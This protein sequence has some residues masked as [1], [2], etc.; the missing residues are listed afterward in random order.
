MG[1]AT[2]TQLATGESV[3]GAVT[4]RTVLGVT[5]ATVVLAVACLMQWVAPGGAVVGIPVATLLGGG[6]AVAGCGIAVL[7][8]GSRLEYIET[9]PSRATSLAAGCVVGMLWAVSGGVAT[10]VAVGGG[11]AWLP[12]AVV[13]GVA[14]ALATVLPREDAGATLPAAA[15]IVGWGGAIA[16]SGGGG[17]WTWAPAWSSAVFPGTEIVPVVAVGGALLAAWSGASAHAGF[18]AEGRQAGAYALVGAVVVGTLSV[19]VLLVGFVVSKGI[20]PV[21]TGAS[22]TG[23]TLGLPFVDAAVPWPTLP[24]VTNQTGG[25]YVTIPGVFPA[26]VGTLWLVFGAIVA[27]VPLGIG[28]AVFLTEYAERGRFTQLVEVATNGLWSTP[29]IVFGLFGL[30][31]LVPRLSGGN[32]IL[33]GQLVLGCMLLP[34]VLLTCREA[35]LAVP[36]AHRDAS[37]ALGVTKWQT[38]RSVVV[39]AAMPGTITGVI[40]GVGRIAGETAPLLLV[41]G[42]APYPSNTPDVL[43]SFSLT[44]QPPFVTND[45]LLAPASALPYQLY[46]TITA[47]VFPKD[48]FTTAA[49]GWGTALV[50]LAVVIGLYAVG[51]ASRRYFRRKLHHE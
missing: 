31:F 16:A 42:G 38:I 15:V 39:P 50:L 18:G 36:D 35:L 26:L 7:G 48:E 27:A 28:A 19:L 5:A 12:V 29:S 23:G 40:L 44:A 30:A 34:L 46:T 45:A 22:L 41:F 49:F 10:T 11:D 9:T 3:V 8:A 13:G 32:S 6:L 33:V 24:F 4:S 47:G 25:L 51:I 1:T 17:G 21:L 2:K 20:T 37:A 14:G 43:G